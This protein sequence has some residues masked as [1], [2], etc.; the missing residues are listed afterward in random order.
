MDSELETIFG[1]SEAP[2]T[3]AT[4]ALGALSFQTGEAFVRRIVWHGVEVVRAI[5]Y[6]IRDERWG[7]IQTRTVRSRTTPGPRRVRQ[8]REFHTEDG[9]FSGRF[10]LI[11]EAAGAMTLSLRLE[12]RRDA[13]LCRAGFTA[14]HPIDGL[15]G[16][17]MT[18]RRPD[19][20]CIGSEFAATISPA[21]PAV[22]F[23]GVR[24]QIRGAAVAVDIEGDVFDMEDQRNWSDA[25]YKSYVRTASFPGPYTVRRGDVINQ[26]LT[27]AFEGEP[28]IAAAPAVRP[29]LWFEQAPAMDPF[30]ELALAVDAAWTNGFV[31]PGL[32]SLRRTVRLDL[33]CP[34][35]PFALDFA[36]TSPHPPF[37]LELVVPDDPN[38]IQ[39]CL[40]AVAQ[41][42][43]RAGAR[44]DHVIALPAAYLRSWQPGGPWPKGATPLDATRAARAAFPAARIGGGALTNFTEFNRRRPDAREVDYVT[45][46]SS[47][48]VHAA[49][50]ESVFQTLEALPDI[51]RSGSQIAAGKPY[52]LGLISI[53]MRENPYGAGLAPNP[54][55]VRPTMCEWDPRAQR[56]FGEAWLVGVAAA[57]RRAGLSL[58]TLASVGG[59]FAVAQGPSA[60]APSYHVMVWLARMQGRQRLDPMTADGGIHVVAVERN[61]GA[62]ALLANGSSTSRTLE[63][64]LPGR[65]AVLDA[66]SAATASRDCDWTRNAA[67]GLEVSIT[68]PPY[69]VAFLD[70]AAIEGAA[71]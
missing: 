56:L 10:E 48:T 60:L 16:R 34:P 18:I 19:G 17:P 68:L 39:D 31:P 15:A 54:D 6:P 14:L 57:S 7:T 46:G 25:S 53:G 2:E 37:D 24:Y 44:P 12:A 58:L 36:R 32:A 22:N 51:F 40:T 4:V 41:W 9:A 62:I 1:T 59:P 35:N 42:L 47:A 11:A 28:A 20:E 8:E 26:R 21:Q 67:H 49:D 45:H 13:R 69:A 71:A 27:L 43:K 52:P 3:L 5:D 61:G 23:A 64:G 70:A 38:E 63:C 65:I 66:S 29:F 50:D 30:P 55:R 33:R